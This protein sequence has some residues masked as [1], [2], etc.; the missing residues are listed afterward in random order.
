MKLQTVSDSPFDQVVSLTA[1][2]V[3]APEDGDLGQEVRPRC[4]QA[5]CFDR[6][7]VNLP[8]SWKRAKQVCQRFSNPKSQSFGLVWHSPSAYFHGGPGATYGP[9]YDQHEQYG[10]L[11]AAEFPSSL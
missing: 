7:R 8:N 4:N 6:M 5:R 2:L 3:V 9:N 1:D 10:L 11:D